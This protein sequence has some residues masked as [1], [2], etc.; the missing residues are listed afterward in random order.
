[1]E[2]YRERFPMWSERTIARFHRAMRIMDAVGVPA[3]T[4]GSIV[5]TSTRGT[6]TINVARV[7]RRAEAAAAVHL[8]DH[9][10]VHAGLILVLNPIEVNY[11]DYEDN[12]RQ[13]QLRPGEARA[14]AR[15]LDDDDNP[16]VGSLALTLRTVANRLDP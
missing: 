8:R 3:D 2:T 14:L 12:L 7:E 15:H 11:L 5:N 10:A 6:G 13:M 4:Q 1:L 16:E 9:F